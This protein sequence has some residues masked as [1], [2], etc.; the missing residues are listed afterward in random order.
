MDNT[1]IITLLIK[2]LSINFFSYLIFFKI[3]NDKNIKYIKTFIASLTITIMYLV[4]KI[5]TDQVLAIIIS[6]FSQILLLKIIIENKERGIFVP[7]LIANAISYISFGIA[8][9]IEI[10]P[11]LI[12]NNYNNITNVIFIVLIQFL[13]LWFCSKI[14]RFKN[15]I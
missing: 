14:K 8:M 7:N 1:D 9:A 2:N 13:I 15:R 11:I 5:Y 3:T 12:F 4:I 10:I 6:Y